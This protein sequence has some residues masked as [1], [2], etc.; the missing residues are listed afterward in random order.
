MDPDLFLTI[1]VV[2][3]ILTI[4]SLFSA[5]T[6]GR[7]PRM[8]AIMLIAAAGL[9]VAAVTKKPGGYAVGD[10]PHVMMSVVGRYIN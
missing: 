4:P 3:A 7:A 1:G 5:W 10:V 9:V 8:G 6:D 2:L